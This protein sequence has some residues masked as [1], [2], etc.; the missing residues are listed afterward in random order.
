[1]PPQ[2]ACPVCAIDS[3]GAAVCGRCLTRPPRFDA[4]HAAFPYAFPVR[5]LVHAFKFQAR[6]GTGRFL[7]SRLV[8]L[9]SGIQA[10]CVVAAPLHPQRL[11]SRG[12]N[13]SIL[14]AR[15]VAKALRVPLLRDAVSK[16]RLVPPQAGL[17]LEERRRNLRGVFV[18]R[19]R[20][21]GERVL[22]VD[23]VMTSGTTLDEL[24]GALK[25]AGAARVEAVVVARTPRHAS[26]G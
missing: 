12:F 14:L 1:M 8:G 18:T 3:P 21:D 11:A 17:A 20:F 5:E 10:D 25:A 16:A 26:P 23:D 15:P 6:F 19:R 4:T 24:A 13:Q 7:A 9:A 2:E 22:V